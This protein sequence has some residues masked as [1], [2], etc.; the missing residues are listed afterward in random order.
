[1][2]IL[3]FTLDEKFFGVSL[4]SVKEIVEGVTITPVPLAQKYIDGVMNLRGDPIPIVDIKKKLGFKDNST[5]NDII[6]CYIKDSVVGLRPDQILTIHKFST[7]AFKD[8]P[9]SLEEDIESRYLKGIVQIGEI[10]YIIIN[11]DELI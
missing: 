6:L 11:V 5:S 3:S 7:D 10:K 4:D 2:E 1:M 9:S 8:V